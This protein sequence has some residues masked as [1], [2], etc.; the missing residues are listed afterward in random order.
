MCCRPTTVC[1]ARYLLVLANVQLRAWFVTNTRASSEACS[2]VARSSVILSSTAATATETQF[3][4]RHVLMKFP[5]ANSMTAVS[6][7]QCTTAWLH[8]G[9]SSTLRCWHQQTMRVQRR[10]KVKVKLGYIIVRS[11]A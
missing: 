3:S 9:T 10:V 6:W 7:R 4:S 5:A 11:K 2:I 1:T 8:V